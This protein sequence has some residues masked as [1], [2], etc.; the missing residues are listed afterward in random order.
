VREDSA[1]VQKSKNPLRIQSKAQ[2]EQRFYILAKL[3]VEEFAEE[4]GD[5][6]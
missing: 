1:R 3:R 6:G 4:K 2:E 5:K